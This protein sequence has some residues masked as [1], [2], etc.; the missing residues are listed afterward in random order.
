MFPI[1]LSLLDI[2]TMATI[3]IILTFYVIFL[4]KLK[5][6]KDDESTLNRY[7]EKKGKNIKQ[8]KRLEKPTTPAK[9]K[10]TTNEEPASVV[11][12]Q[13]IPEE[14]SETI[15]SKAPVETEENHRKK[16]SKEEKKKSFMLFGNSDF[17]GCA[18]KFGYLK[19]LPKN[20][21]I[22][23]KCFGCPKIIQCLMPSK[24]K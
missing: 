3:V 7:F 22:P 5:P 21:P 8:P 12:T 18:H 13:K 14:P 2:A 23:D 15:Q 4:R 9:T 17:E 20:T 1:G 11:K 10:K 16:K 24:N 19:S 6:P